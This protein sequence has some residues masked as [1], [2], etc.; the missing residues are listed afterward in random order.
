MLSQM[1]RHI[2]GNMVFLYAFGPEIEDGMG[3]LRYLAFYLLSGLVAF[4]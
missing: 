3:R 2:L 4:Y 1:E